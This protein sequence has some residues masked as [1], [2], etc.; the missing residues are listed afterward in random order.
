MEIEEKNK[1]FIKEFLNSKCGTPLTIRK[2]VYKID[3]EKFSYAKMYNLMNENRIFKYIGNGE[4]AGVNGEGQGHIQMPKEMIVNKMS[5]YKTFWNM[6]RK[7]LKK[8]PCFEMFI[9]T[10]FMRGSY[11]NRIKEIDKY[12]TGNNR[13]TYLILDGFKD[14]IE[15][16]IIISYQVDESGG[17]N[18]TVITAYIEDIIYYQ[19]ED[20][21]PILNYVIMFHNYEEKCHTLDKIVANIYEPMFDNY[22]KILAKILTSLGFKKEEK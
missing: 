20:I 8:S 17:V 10:D 16:M 6:F 12:L 11:K 9:K 7:F 1:N 15:S 2:Y 4:I 19:P 21:V 5:L 18:S 22:D 14:E 3:G 13:A